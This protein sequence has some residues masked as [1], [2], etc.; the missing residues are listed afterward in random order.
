MEGSKVEDKPSEPTKVSQAPLEANDGKS[1][2]QGPKTA[3]G[4]KVNPKT[5][6]SNSDSKPAKG[7]AKTATVVNAS[8]G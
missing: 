4:P 3:D 8:T 6:I 2:G 1:L 5:G 7:V